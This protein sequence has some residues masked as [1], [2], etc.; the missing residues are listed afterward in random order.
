MGELIKPTKDGDTKVKWDPNN[1]EE[2]EV[3]REAFKLYCSQGY[4]AA[5]MHNKEAGELIREFD[6]SAN[7]ILFLTPLAGG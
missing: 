6:P 1:T 7:E 4:R 2:V 3:A 5:K